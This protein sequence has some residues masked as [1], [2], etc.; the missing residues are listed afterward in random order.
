MVPLGKQFL[1]RFIPPQ[2]AQPPVPAFP[3]PPEAFVPGSRL[4]WTTGA[5][6]VSPGTQEGSRLAPTSLADSKPPT[7]QSK[8]TVA[9]LS[10]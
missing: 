10:H 6:A 1:F 5:C 3:M 9:V 4:L 8:E 7:P 2:G